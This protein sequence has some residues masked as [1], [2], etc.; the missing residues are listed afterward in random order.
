MRLDHLLSMEKRKRDLSKLQGRNY[1]YSK[2]LFNFESPE[3]RLT[4]LNEY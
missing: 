1:G 4:A 3:A 2:A